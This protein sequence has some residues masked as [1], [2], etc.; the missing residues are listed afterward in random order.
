MIK[1]LL[2]EMINHSSVL[3]YCWFINQ[4]LSVRS[5]CKKHYPLAVLFL[6]L[7]C[8]LT[9]IC[10]HIPFFVT[11]LGYTLLTLLYF[12]AQIAF[13]CLFYADSLWKKLFYFGTD[14]IIEAGL[15]A[16][17]EH[18]ILHMPKDAVGNWLANTFQQSAWGFLGNTVIV[19]ADLAVCWVFVCC[20]RLFQEKEPKWAERLCLLLIPLTQGL[21]IFYCFYLTWKAYASHLRNATPFLAAI[22]ITAAVGDVLLF[23]TLAKLKKKAELEKKIELMELQQNQNLNELKNIKA[24]SRRQ[25]M[26]NHDLKNQII[27]AFYCMENS[28][29]E[30]SKQYISA[31]NDMIR[32]YED[33]SYCS[34][35]VIN[36]VLNYKKH[37]AAGMGIQLDYSVNLTDELPFS[38][39]DVCSLFSNIL[40]NA[41]NALSRCE[42]NDS[43]PKATLS[44]QVRHGCFLLREE[45]AAPGV[46]KDES[47]ADR[48][49]HG[50]GLQ[51]LNY[52]A[53]KY[54]GS[55]SIR[56]EDERY[57]VEFSAMI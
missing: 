1:I 44:C 53:E 32:Q 46:E 51:I 21:F 43:P 37:V 27:T 42:N 47:E 8:W 5:E 34:N 4:F 16:L 18:V 11:P 55:F 25:Q 33:V 29:Y 39:A 10:R 24:A 15:I 36:S 2:L 3:V 20:I 57:I 13:L 14:K 45:N 48:S 9:G 52:I 50:F 41:I 54:S 26:I 40:D 31:I 30:Q 19:F 28:D 17:S 49:L 12:S 23:E 7:F 56:N 38:D 35:P 6:F 22:T